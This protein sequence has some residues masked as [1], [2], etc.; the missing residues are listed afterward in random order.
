MPLEGASSTCGIAMRSALLGR[1]RRSEHG[2]SSCAATSAPMPTAGY[3]SRRS[4]RLVPG[5]RSPHP[6]QDPHRPAR[7]RPRVHLA[8]VLR[9]RTEP[10]RVRDRRVRAE[11]P[12]GPAERI[13]PD[14][15]PEWRG[16]APRGHPG[17][18]RLPCDLPDRGPAD[19]TRDWRPTVRF[20]GDSH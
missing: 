4:P 15:Q 5:S 17:R 9:R 14:L 10:H 16:D 2:L 1:R 7:R 19:L 8:A 6:L 20:G 12:A 11:G 3:R 18:R 13:R